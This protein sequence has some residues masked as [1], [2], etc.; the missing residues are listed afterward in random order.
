MYVTDLTHFLDEKGAIG[1]KAGQARRMAEFLTRVVAAASVV[2]GDDDAPMPPCKC[3][4]CKGMVVAIVG[5]DDAIEWWCPQ[6]G[7]EGHISHWRGSFWDLSQQSRQP[8]GATTRGGDQ[9]P[10]D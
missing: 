1:P 5:S 9:L 10:G 8:E 4:K 3:L 6:C 7:R 2:E